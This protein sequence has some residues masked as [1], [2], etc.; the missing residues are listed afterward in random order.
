MEKY[1]E[2]YDSAR[3]GKSRNTIED[4]TGAYIS[5][6]GKTVGIIGEMTAV[7][8]ARRAIESLIEGAQHASVY[9]WLEKQRRGMK[10]KEMVDF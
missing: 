6:Y 2:F 4:L 10:K 3:K 1:P 7:P 8:L 5:V 9:K